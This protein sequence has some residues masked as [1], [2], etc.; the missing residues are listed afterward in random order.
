[1]LLATLLGLEPDAFARRLR[2]VRPMLPDFIDRLH[3]RGLRV[4][5]ARAD[6][7][8][9]RADGRLAVDVQVDGDL[10]VV[11]EPGDE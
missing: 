4:G 7:A 6:L 10:D 11:V 9:T 2:I 5:A 1:L 3:V 8:F